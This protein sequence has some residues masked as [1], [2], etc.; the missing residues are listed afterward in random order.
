MSNLAEESTTVHLK[1]LKRKIV[2][3]AVLRHKTVAPGL[4]GSMHQKPTLLHRSGSRHLYSHMLATAH[5][6]Y[7][8]Q[9]MGA[10]FRTYI[11]KVY[12]GQLAS[13]LPCIRPAQR[14]RLFA[15]AVAQQFIGTCQSLTVHIDNATYLGIAD[16]SIAHQSLCAAIAKS[17][18]RNAHLGN[19][20]TT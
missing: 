8:H 6:V 12:V 17:H 14:E 15:M 7:S 9:C 1:G 19:S 13:L 10:P 5:S 16:K 18:K 20:R 2:I 4:L 3:A 11:Y